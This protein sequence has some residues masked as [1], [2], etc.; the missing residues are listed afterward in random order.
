M[1]LTQE[2]SSALRR[3]GDSIRSR[4]TPCNK[5]MLGQDRSG[6]RSRMQS[7]TGAIALSQSEI[8]NRVGLNVGNVSS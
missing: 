2:Y 5:V 1:S 6:Q 8:D 7:E 3:H 4:I